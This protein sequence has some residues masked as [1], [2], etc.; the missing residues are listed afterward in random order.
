MN[1][2]AKKLISNMHINED[3]KIKSVNGKGVIVFNRRAGFSVFKDISFSLLEYLGW[4]SLSFSPYHKYMIVRVP[5]SKKEQRYVFKY[6]ESK[7]AIVQYYP[8][9][10][11]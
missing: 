4:F 10:F 8:I 5:Y 7:S 9:S 11:P 6:R 1:G 3:Y 2:V